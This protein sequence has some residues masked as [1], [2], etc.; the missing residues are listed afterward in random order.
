VFPWKTAPPPAGTPREVTAAEVT[1]MTRDSRPLSPCA[2]PLLLL[3]LLPGA[4]CSP[5]GGSGAS[6]GGSDGG[7]SDGGGFDAGE[8]DP[9]ESGATGPDA[10][11]TPDA[12]SD[13]AA[14]H[15]AASD[16]GTSLAPYTL[17][18]T[19][20][21]SGATVSGTTTVTGKAPGFLN[22]EVW[23]ATHQHPPLAQVA[24]QPDGTFTTTVAT[25][26]LP[27]GSDAWT[28]WAWD[29]A[30]GQPA[31]HS[32]SVSLPVVIASGT[33]TPDAGPGALGYMVG[34]KSNSVQN[35]AAT[36]QGWLGRPLDL[37]GTTI[38]TTSY[39]GGSNSAYTDENGALPLLEVSF[40]LVSIFGENP[41][42]TDMAQAAAGAYDSVY[43]AMSADL[44]SF[45]NQL[46]SARIGWEFN[47]SW[48]AWSNGVGTNATYANYVSAF[49]HAAQMLRKH[50]PHVLIQWCVAWGQPDPTPY[51]PGAYDATTNP[52]GVDVISIDFYQANISQY[53]NGG[54][55]SSWALAQSG[56][57]IDLDWVAAFAQ[58]NGVR[59]ALSEYGAGSS[60][61]GGIGSGHGLD[62]GVWTAASIA[63][64]NAQ[65]PGFFL[66]SLWSDDAPADDIVTPGANPGE[67]AAWTSAWGGTHFAGTWWTGNAP[68]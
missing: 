50:N 29:S 1:R 53:N 32:A 46:L 4:A 58:K 25:A 40:P 67:Q 55:Q 18:V 41:A 57:T 26:S 24:P 45:P 6:T 54:Q 49:Q 7:G 42:Y 30:P 3:L 47:G 15:D 68:P 36:V 63:W 31:T 64:I 11:G 17:V 16:T 56:T 23:D 20:P 13:V 44:A 59:I 35:G 10:A 5:N 14:S 43:E 2:L 52:G 8:I 34:I 62:D 28:V 48:Y 60:S 66:W 39:V 51:W 12:S 21:A 38:T 27:S 33:A 22:V 61:S 19:A 9:S 37:V 65:P